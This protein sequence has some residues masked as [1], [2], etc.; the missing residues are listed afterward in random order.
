MA[1]YDVTTAAASLEF[2]TQQGQYNSCA[3]I[4]ST[5]FINFWNGVSDDG[6]AQVFTVDGGTF[7]V[8]TA[9]AALEYDTQNSFEN[10]TI[11]ID[12]NHY[13]L[14]WSG[15]AATRDSFAQVIEVNTTTW[16]VTTAAARLQFDTDVGAFYS[17][18]KMDTNHFL[19]VWAGASADGFA[20]ILTVNTTTWAV[21]TAAASLEF[22]TQNLAGSSCAKIDDTH[23]IVSWFG[24]AAGITG[25]AQVLAIN[26]TTWAITTA[27][28]AFTYDAAASSTI[29]PRIGQIDANHF[30][31]VWAGTD[32]DG[33]A[34]SL[35]VNLSTWV[36]STTAASLE[37]D[38]EHNGANEFAFIDSS[39][40]LIVWQDSAG[41][42]RAQ[43]LTISAPTYAITTAAAS[44]E[45]DTQSGA[46]PAVVRIDT[47]H[48]LNFWAGPGNDGFTQVF[49]VEL[50][51][52]EVKTYMGLATASVKT[53]FGLAIA[54]RKTWDGLA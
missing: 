4:D 22:D 40:A 11:R 44:L 15:N 49:T 20:Q 53:T 50:P 29:N 51:T 36:I 3:A 31:N 41:D 28:A 45:Y 1:S 7:A 8:T 47:A 35:E 24:G 21:S 17:S 13:L 6:F 38:T 10:Y 39:H 30:L 43:V 18:A 19:I 12:T 32:G 46:F 34:Q 16:A 5:H 37:F 23:A 33:F 2:D 9:A 25:E 27:A 14:L 48:Y 26:T 54:S 42:G 52:S